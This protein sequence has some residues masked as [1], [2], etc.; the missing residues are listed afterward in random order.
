MRSRLTY[1]PQVAVPM[2][3][4][5]LVTRSAAAARERDMLA[6]ARLTVALPIIELLPPLLSI[7]TPHGMLHS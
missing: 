5:R 3:R 1:S 7:Q 4:D 2:L 6:S